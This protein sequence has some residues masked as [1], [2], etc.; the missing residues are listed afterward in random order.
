MASGMETAVEKLALHQRGLE[1]GLRK[2][3]EIVSKANANLALVLQSAWFRGAKF[4]TYPI[5]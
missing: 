4:D 1:Q 5:L 3:E 2:A